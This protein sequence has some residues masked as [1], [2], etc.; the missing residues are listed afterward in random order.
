MSTTPAHYR[1]E[2]LKP[3]FRN[4][5]SG[6]SFYIVGAPSVGKTR[7]MDFVMG[8]DP[9]ALWAGEEV[10]RDWVKNKYLGEDIA[11]RVWLVRVDMNRMRHENDWSFQFYELLL[12]TLLLTCNRYSDMEKIEA[13]KEHLAALDSQVIQSKDALMAHRLFE[14]AVN[15]ICQSYKIQIC[16]V[17]D[18][19]DDTYQTMPREVFAQ[20]RAIRDANKYRLTYILFLRNLPEKLRSPKDN[21]SYY[22]LISRN[23]LGLGPYSAMDSFH[24]IGQLEKRKDHE[25]GKEDREWVWANS[26]GH[27]GLIQALFSLLKD[28][29]LTAAQMQNT[30][31]LAKQE[32]ISEEF[33]KIWEGLLED[34]QDALKKIAHGDQKTVSPSTG[35]LLLAKGMIKPS[36]NQSIVLFNPLFEY[37]IP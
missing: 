34:E 35:K 7:L 10:D 14:M 15:M 8:D 37:W 19:F 24:I 30:E 36:S 32:M 27:P 33:R 6:E 26:G 21:E 3:F 5:K 16:F 31:W 22:E 4:V 11:S 29:P 20:L 12:H 2:V 17:F 1:E 23:M 25:L 28:K 13:L 18:E 9:D